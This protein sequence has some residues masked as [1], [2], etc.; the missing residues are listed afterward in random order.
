MTDFSPIPPGDALSGRS[1]RIADHEPNRMNEP[2]AREAALKLEASFLSEMLKAAGFGAREGA[3]SGGAG[4]DQFASLYR[5]AVA[6][7]M[8]RSG[9]LGLGE[10]FYQSILEAQNE[11]A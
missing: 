6:E 11:R 1:R 5:D 2:R 7:Q 3:F 8:V 9:G 10:H 4:E